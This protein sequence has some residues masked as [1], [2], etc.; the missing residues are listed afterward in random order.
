MIFFISHG[1]ECVSI[2]FYDNT[3]ASSSIRNL[4]CVTLSADYSKYIDITHFIT[5]HDPIQHISE[6]VDKLYGSEIA[7]KDDTL[8]EFF[9]NK[10]GIVVVDTLGRQFVIPKDNF[11]KIAAKQV[12]VG[13]KYQP[14][15]SV[16]EKV[17]ALTFDDGPNYKFTPELLSMLKE[18]DVKATFL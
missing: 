9:V 1:Q 12:F 3:S 2:I 17:I 18:K 7:I 5:Y 11:Y 6:T 15:T 8:P 14:V 13:K 16:S 4:F 10:R